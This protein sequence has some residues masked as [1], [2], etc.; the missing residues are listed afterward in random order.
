MFT[1]GTCIAWEGDG[2]NMSKVKMSKKVLIVKKKRSKVKVPKKAKK[3]GPVATIST[4]PVAIGNSVRGSSS[5]VIPTSEGVRVVGRDFCFPATATGSVQT[6]TLCGGTPLTPAAFSDSV[7]SRYLQMYQK[8]KWNR[9]IA[10]YI[11]SSPTSA[12]GDVL[13]YHGKNR[14][15]VFLNQTST[16]FLPFVMSDEDT[17]IGPQWTNH[18]VDLHVTPQWKST[19]YGMSSSV[20]DYSSGELFLMSKT[21]T[22][23]SPGYV[24]FDY[25]VSFK[26]LQISPRLLSLPVPRAQFTN[27]SVGGSAITLTAGS[28]MTLANYGN[29]ISGTASTIPSGCTNGDIYRV[30]ID[31]TNSAT[32]PSGITTLRSTEGGGYT[33]FSTQDGTTIYAVY[34]GT[35]FVFYAT[36]DSAITNGAGLQYN[37]TNTGVTF[38]LQLWMSLVTTVASFN[39]NPNF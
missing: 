15:S 38:T 5:S 13:F 7:L 14:S 9:L 29:T 36:I 21:S 3:F 26:E 25:D 35:N 39:V 22:T 33:T 16:Q 34:N 17:V 27:V 32:V 12:N 31:L 2:E 28:A 18:S 30:F 24:I 6:W 10:H 19:D 11:T 37:A 8:F 20:D 4:A 1:S 23:D